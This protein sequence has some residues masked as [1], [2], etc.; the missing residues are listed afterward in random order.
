MTRDEIDEFLARPLVGVI[1]TMDAEGPASRDA[2]LVLVAG[3]RGPTCSPAG[4]R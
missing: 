2:Y 3:R 1:T 4:T